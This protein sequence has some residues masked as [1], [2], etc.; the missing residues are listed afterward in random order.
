MLS[1]AFSLKSIENHLTVFSS[2]PVSSFLNLTP[3][4]IP[5]PISLSF[6]LIKQKKLY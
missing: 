5:D 6:C 4:Q 3:N 1:K 2:S